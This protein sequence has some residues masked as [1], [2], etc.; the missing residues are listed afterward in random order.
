MPTSI[1]I[2]HMG[3]I[4]KGIKKSFTYIHSY[5]FF[6]VCRMVNNKLH[7]RH[8]FHGLS[9]GPYYHFAGKEIDTTQFVKPH[10]FH[11][12]FK[13]KLNKDFYKRLEILKKGLKE[14]KKLIIYL[15]NLQE[16]RG[17]FRYRVFNIYEAM[18]PSNKYAVSFFYENELEYLINN[19]HLF[20][21]VVISR[22]ALTQHLESL[23]AG[24]KY[25]GIPCVFD[26][27]DVFYNPKY[28][29]DICKDTGIPEKWYPTW[30]EIS[31]RMEMSASLCNY[32]ILTNNY[33]AEDFYNNF[34]IPTF[35]FPNTINQEQ[36]LYASKLKKRKGDDFI[37][38]YFS[39]SVTHNKDF[40]IA[41]NAIKEFLRKHKDAKL[42]LVGDINIPDD[43]KE[44]I[45]TKQIITHEKVNMYKLL[46][47][48]KTV[49]VSVVPLTN[50]KFT[51]CKSELK[52][53]ESALVGVPA[54]CS[55][56]YVYTQCVKN[57]IN[58]YLVN[59]EKEWLN[60]LEEA[61]GNR[62]NNE[63]KEKGRNSA[64]NNYYIHSLKEYLENIYD[65]ILSHKA[66]NKLYPLSFKEDY[67]N[68]TYQSY[69][70]PIDIRRHW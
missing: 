49:S 15:Y 46:E 65:L 63:L 37:I 45:K 32:A 53:F 6:N 9:E 62:N 48:N 50:S 2:N 17:T 33:L 13:T 59:D 40:A 22:F 68:K 26:I 43:F 25:Y 34:H 27:D 20:S 24:A 42:K 4:G 56:T 58:S 67:E 70:L 8:I 66:E 52:F 57:G 5:G 28:I 69:D 44:F 41:S 36:Y 35:V 31:M 51:N 39:G 18:Y 3:K 23:L 54:I 55:N 21:M 47:Q 1:E 60:A 7:K 12:P 30:L 38:G 14:G 29:G 61:Y 19:V 10:K 11:I 64:I 16:N